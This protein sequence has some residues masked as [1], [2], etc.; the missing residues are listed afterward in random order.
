MTLEIRNFTTHHIDNHIL[1]GDDSRWTL[2]GFYGRPKE[3]RKWES[4]ALLEQLNKCCSL[5][6]LCCGDFNEILEQSEKR[7]KRL[8]PWRRMCEF[9]EVVNR[10]QFVDLEYKGYKFTW[11]NNQD[12]RAFVEERL[13]CALA[14]SS[15]TN[16]IN[17][18]LV[19]HLQISKSDHIP[20]LVEAANQSS[21]TRNK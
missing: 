5:P 8:R 17:V 14:T 16:M 12:A 20:I 2:T 19:M 6:W 21:Q 11:N 3:Q 1:H 7:G 18:M 4:W 9:R 15:R 10:C 13:D